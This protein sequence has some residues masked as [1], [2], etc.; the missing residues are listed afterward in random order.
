MCIFGDTGLYKCSNRTYFL[1]IVGCANILIVHILAIIGVWTFSAVKRLIAIYRIQF[2]C[3]HNMC[4]LCIFI[5]YINT[6]T[7]SI[8]LENIYMY[9]HVYIYIH[10]IYV[11]YKY[12]IYKRYIFFLIYTCM[13]VYLYIHNKYTQYTHI[14]Y[15]NK[16]FYFGSD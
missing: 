14:Y 13:C 11:I 12:V 8:Y 15:E 9:L 3:L 5:V 2:F 7:Y 6:H 10:I 16:N 4:V 1:G